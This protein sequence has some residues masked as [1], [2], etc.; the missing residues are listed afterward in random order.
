MPS[1]EPDHRDEESVTKLLSALLR[2]REDAR[3]RHEAGASGIDVTRRLSDTVDRV[4]SAIFDAVLARRPG[5]NR[6]APRLTVVATGGYGRRRLS[7]HSDIDIAFV[8]GEED[9]P[10]LDQ[11]VKDM[12]FLITAVFTEGAGL[13]VT[14]AYRT[15]LDL[16]DLD[17]QSQ[18][19]LLDARCVAGD[20]SLFYHFREEMMQNIRPAVFVWHKLHERADA[21]KTY[22]DSV[23]LVEPNVKMGAGGLRDLHTAEWLAKA[24]MGTGFDDPWG[25]LRAIGLIEE[26]EFHAITAG[27]EFLLRVRN[28]IQWAAGRLT[29][30][31]T[32]DVQPALAATF[33]Y[34]DSP[35][36]TAVAAMMADY[37][38]HAATIQRISRKVEAKRLKQPLRL[39]AGLVLKDA[40]ISATDLM[41]LEKDPAAALRIIQLAQEYDFPLSPEANELIGDFAARGEV[42]LDD[43]DSR[44]VFLQILRRP[45][46]VYAA[47]RRMADL[48]LL[49][50]VLPGYG[51]LLRLLPD[52][53][54]RAHTVG[55]HSLHVVRE[56]ERMRSETERTIYPE[57]FTALDRPAVLTL[58]ALLHDIGEVEGS[59]DPAAAGVERARAIGEALGL[60][61][62][63][64]DKLAF[65]VRYYDLMPR[66]TRGRD[67]EQ[68][69]T[70]AELAR[71]ITNPAWLGPLFLLACADLRALGA[72]TWIH[73]QLEFLMRL[74]LRTEH[75]LSRGAASDVP[76]D[77]GVDVARVREVL[78]P[79]EVSEEEVRTFCDAMPASYLLHTGPETI[80][81]HIALME[82]QN[83]GPAIDF[84]SEHPRP[85]TVIT[86]AAPDSPGLL[87]DIA[88]VLYAHDV[89][90]HAARLFTRAGAPAAALDELW[91]ESRNQPLSARQERDLGRDLRAVLSGDLSLPAL[92][93]REGRE[94]ATPASGITGRIHNDAS[95]TFSVVE[96][97]MA[98]EKGLLYRLASTMTALG[99]HISHARVVT[100]AGEARDTFYVTDA[101]GDKLDADEAPLGGAVAGA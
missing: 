93:E 86:V 14:Y 57:V 3:A 44:R 54:A 52:Q 59:D 4:L 100:T 101:A 37:Y 45:A 67:P 47:L 82:R 71:V 11:M 10:V 62:E 24:T 19:A 64:L 20:K 18:T 30:D 63:G 68:P 43:Q 40:Q 77:T 66:L 22:G 85:W 41:L 27:R 8:V 50:R 36:L 13:R 2:G 29:D 58:A 87:A 16:E 6:R 84:Q 92:L 55:E 99:W 33:G 42:T 89:N 32:A 1:P 34:A 9:D 90:V 25:R 74:Y 26:D 91:V 53:P 7:P 46:N 15:V 96:V 48:G 23:Y 69:E 75:A 60:D 21:L 56:L 83:S 73:V 78:G 98:D 5:R 95:E 79:E 70:V 51:S 39:D 17:T 65:L 49:P 81:R 35:R 31:L 76:E 38:R 97:E 80:A 72:E 12:F 94:P 28:G 61:E 88:G